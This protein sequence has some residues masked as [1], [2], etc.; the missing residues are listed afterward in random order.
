[1]NIFDNPFY[2]L[3]ATT[4]DNK[5]KI[6]ELAQEKS[7]ILEPAIVIEARNTFTNPRIRITAV[8]IMQGYKIF[9][10]RT[11]KEVLKNE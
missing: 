9:E 7:L 8:N 11:P 5:Q 2:I 1:M 10:I 6:L 3:S 4:R